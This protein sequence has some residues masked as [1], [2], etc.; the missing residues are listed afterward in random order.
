[1]QQMFNVAA[2]EGISI[3]WCNFEP[4]IRGMYWDPIIKNPVIWLDKSLEYNTRILR[5]VMAEEL[6]HHFTLDRDCLTR[7]YFNY[8]DRLAVSR[9][10]YRALRWAAKLLVPGDKLGQA[11][12][13]G[14]RERWELAEYFEVTEEM[15]E[16]R[17]GDHNCW[18]G[19]QI[20]KWQLEK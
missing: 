18:G 9:A 15:V 10:E 7:T 5:C 4:P 2:R 12:R 14:I 3:R 11:I 17:L 8:R 20:D 19:R 1:L 13:D 6:G 16:F